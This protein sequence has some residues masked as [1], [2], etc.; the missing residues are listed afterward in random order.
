MRIHLPAVRETAVLYCFVLTGFALLLFSSCKKDGAAKKTIA[1]SG[2][3]WALEYV[4]APTN[5]RV[6]SIQIKFVYNGAQRAVVAVAVDSASSNGR[7]YIKDPNLIAPN[8]ILTWDKYNPNMITAS[9][10]L[11]DTF[12]ITINKFVTVNGA[13]SA[14]TFA[15][16][17][18][19]NKLTLAFTPST[20]IQVRGYRFTT[21]DNSWA[22]RYLTD[23]PGFTI[24]MRDVAAYHYFDPAIGG[25]LRQFFT[26]GV[27]TF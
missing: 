21:R 10:P 3:I 5:D 18:E 15:D 12:D 26:I 9:N 7:L 23:L 13:G 1:I 4:L 27:V 25:P 16:E 24:L 17:T 2:Q 6:N 19:Y 14:G 8:S 11:P 22:D 20:K